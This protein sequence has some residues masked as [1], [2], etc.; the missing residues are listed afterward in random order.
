MVVEL[1]CFDYCCFFYYFV[2]LVFFC[3]V[4]FN[5]ISNLVESFVFAVT[6]ELFFRLLSPLP[7]LSPAQNMCSVGLKAGTD[8]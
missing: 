8:A 1:S 4:I 5:N 6:T 2:V 7:L 3:G